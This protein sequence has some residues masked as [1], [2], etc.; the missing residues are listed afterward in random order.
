MKKLFLIVIFSLML[1][2]VYSQQYDIVG[3]NNCYKTDKSFSMG[4]AAIK[5]SMLLDL[6]NMNL[7][8]YAHS[9]KELYELLAA[10]QISEEKWNAY[11]DELLSAVETEQASLKRPY[12]GVDYMGIAPLQA[13]FFLS[14]L[15]L[16]DS[17]KNVYP[18]EYSFL[19]TSASKLKGKG[20]T[21]QD[22][23][24]LLVVAEMGEDIGTSNYY[25][26]LQVIGCPIYKMAIEKEGSDIVNYYMKIEVTS[27]YKVPEYLQLRKLVD[28]ERKLNCCYNNLDWGIILHD[29]DEHY[30][31]F[32]E[33]EF[34][35]HMDKLKNF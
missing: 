8:E 20:Y 17:L 19:K 23:D 4:S 21:I 18:K 1:N 3:V 32:D 2:I 34:P 35:Y 7:Y 12:F 6:H 28:I 9:L 14:S 10:K 26:F 13:E 24:S 29:E 31:D 16:S 22:I 25:F 11:I 5:N 15:E 30:Y 33:R 27:T